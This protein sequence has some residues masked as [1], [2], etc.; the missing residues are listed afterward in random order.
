MK[1]RRRLVEFLTV[2]LT[3]VLCCLFMTSCSEAWPHYGRFWR[4]LSPKGT[5]KVAEGEENVT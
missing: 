3:I 2:A 1:N 5:I 4:E